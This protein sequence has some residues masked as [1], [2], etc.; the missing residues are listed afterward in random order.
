MAIPSADVVGG[1]GVK[2]VVLECLVE[3]AKSPRGL[4]AL[5]AVDAARII[6]Q[7]IISTPQ[8]STH[9][10]AGVMACV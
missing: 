4:R 10:H 1:T 7:V 5:Q 2:D 8:T 3:L 9:F 6:M